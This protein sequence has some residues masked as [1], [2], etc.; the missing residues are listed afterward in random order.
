MGHCDDEA[1]EKE[2]EDCA[3]QSNLTA[4]LSSSLAALPCCVTSKPRVAQGGMNL[5]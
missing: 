1:E 5:S 4:Q 2:E 3:T